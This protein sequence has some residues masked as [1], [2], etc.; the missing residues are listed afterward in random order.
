MRLT[1]HT[2]YAFRVLI[3]LASMPEDRLSTVQEMADHF[4]VSRSHVMKIVQKLAAA[5]IVHASRGQGGG[6]RLGQLRENINL[7]AVI[8]LME[9][10]LTPVN[11]DEPVCIIK[12]NCALKNILF[13]AQLRF[14]EHV[15]QY[16]LAD[17]AEPAVSIVSLLNKAR[18]R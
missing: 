2:D 6:V 17:L 12:K 8:E 7:R 16:T 1:K 15:E 11:C 3:Y 4:E 10:T 18:R 13:D 9:T 5:H 14:L